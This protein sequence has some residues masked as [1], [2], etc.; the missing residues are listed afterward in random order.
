MVN[1]FASKLV[2]HRFEL[3]SCLTKTKKLVFAASPPSIQHLGARA[4]T[5][6][7]RIRIM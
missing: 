2:E 3:R 6:S 4:N 5:G 7:L 1:M